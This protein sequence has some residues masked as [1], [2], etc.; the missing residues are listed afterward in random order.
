MKR[1]IL[2][3]A[4]IMVALAYGAGHAQQEP[5][6]PVM[7]TEQK[8]S[9]IIASQALQLAQSQVTIAE[10]RLQEMAR[11]LAREGYEI[12]LS[13]PSGYRKVE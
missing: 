4:V 3:V 9:L 6:G 5:Q 10:T 13:Q 1:T 2:V 8:Q 11:A 7:T 12:D